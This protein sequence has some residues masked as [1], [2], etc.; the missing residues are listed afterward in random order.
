MGEGRGGSGRGQAVNIQDWE[1]GHKP[2]IGVS[3]MVE[4]GNHT[5]GQLL[6]N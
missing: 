2:I 3:S 4:E 1:L 6:I 5:L